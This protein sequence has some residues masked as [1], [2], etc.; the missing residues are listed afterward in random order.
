MKMSTLKTLLTAICLSAGI[1]QVS[2]QGINFEHDF[3]KALD[4]AKKENKMIFV[5][6][7]TSWCGP[8]K[9]MSAEVFPQKEA[10]DYFNKEFINLKVQCDDKGEGVEL[11]KKYKINAYPTL[12][13][14]DK[15]GNTVHSTAGGLSV[16]ALIELAKTAT[17]PNKNQLAMVKEWDGGNRGHAFAARYFKT[18]IRS[19]RS[20]K[21][22]ADFEKYFGTL[23]PAQKAAKNT[24]ELMGI[25]KTGPFAPSFEYMEQHTG[26]FY[27]TIGKSKI[28]S[29]IAN[30]YLWYF[31]GLQ[32]SGFSNKD[33]TAFNSK[34]KLFKAEKYPF[35]DEYAEFYAVFDSQDANGKDDINIY[36]QRG[37]EFLRKYGKKNDSYTLSL[38][39]MLGNWTGRKNSGAAGIKWMEE[40]LQRNN[41][42]RYLNTYFY[43]L[44]RN[45]NFDKAMEVAQLMKAN[46]IKEN[47]STADIDKQIQM[48]KDL[49]EK[50]K[51]I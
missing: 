4:L 19:Y 16:K 45:F 11:G 50:Y 12:A 48:V 22:N 35:Y 9:M 33:M 51:N 10:G 49:K 1:L 46:A 32:A 20:E 24:F 26:D 18:L 43:I 27:K 6:F 36:M 41:N 21:A 39:S 3:N 31:K 34:M 30:A 38:T 2:A 25:V 8:C 29:T 5:D 40:L 37:T 13:F 15:D 7:Y 23:N 42:P 28:D 17:D 44:W 47:S 14:L